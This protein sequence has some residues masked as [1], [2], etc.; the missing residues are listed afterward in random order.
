M[1]A[2]IEAAPSLESASRRA[3]KPAFRRADGNL[4]FTTHPDIKIQKLAI[5]RERAPLLVIDSLLDNADALV[6][7]AARKHYG[8]VV[9]YYPGIRAKAPLTYQQ[10]ILDKLRG[11]IGEFFELEPRSLRFTDCH[12]SIVTTPADKLE[13]LQWIPHTDSMFGTELAMLHYL[14]KRNL[15]GTAFYRHRATGFEY[16]D[17]ARRPSYLACVDQESNG[18]HRPAAGYITGSTALYEQ[19]SAQ[20]GIFNRL[21]M[22]R[23][24]SLHSGNIAPDFVPDPDPRSGRLSINGFLAANAAIPANSVPDL[25]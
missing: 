19:I 18:P 6:E 15:G 8:D 1:D 7:L 5:G 9:S 16:V 21:L 11:V 23:R 13:Y 4:E 25:R 17:F 10:F 24:N 22:Y 14:F 3:L 2:K 20:E 12:F